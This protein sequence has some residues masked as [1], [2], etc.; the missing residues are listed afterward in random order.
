MDVN[1][2]SKLDLNY[3]DNVVFLKKLINEA[4]LQVETNKQNIVKEAI[5]ND[6]GDISF[7]FSDFTV[8]MS[9]CFNFLKRKQFFVNL[10]P[11]LIHNEKD[12]AKKSFCWEAI[13]KI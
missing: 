6:D 7:I 11:T 2:E 9:I 13:V 5:I 4:F 12:S 10:K 8:T 3:T 1:N